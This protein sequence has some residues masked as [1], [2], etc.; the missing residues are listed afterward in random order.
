MSNLK[1]VLSVI[2]TNLEALVPDERPEVPYRRINSH[3]PRKT[4]GS[5]LHRGFWFEWGN[6]NI[7]LDPSEKINDLTLSV[8]FLANQYTLTTMMDVVADERMAI[9][10]MILNLPWGNGVKNVWVESTDVE[11]QESGNQ[12]I[13]FSLKAFTDETT[14]F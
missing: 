11:E 5:L 3:S 13:N 14:S 6:S 8:G 4:A 12:I 10:T 9:E 7:I 2:T 1:Q